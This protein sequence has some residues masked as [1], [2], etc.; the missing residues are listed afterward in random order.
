MPLGKNSYLI[1]C[2]NLPPNEIYIFLWTLWRPSCETGV[3]GKRISGTVFTL[4][5]HTCNWAEADGNAISFAGIQSWTNWN[6]PDD[7]ATWKVLRLPNG[8][9]V[10]WT[11]LHGN[12]SAGWGE[13]M[14]SRLT[15]R[16]IMLTNPVMGSHHA[17]RQPG[18]W[19]G[20][21]NCPLHTSNSL[22]S[23]SACS[24]HSHIPTWPPFWCQLSACEVWYRVRFHHHLP[25]SEGGGGR[26]MKSAVDSLQWST[27]ASYTVVTLSQQEIWNWN[28]NTKVLLC[29]SL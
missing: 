22:I 25:P 10:A 9:A 3:S 16:Q 11:E 13:M 29:G 17:R 27:T 19:I 15:C 20:A 14:K 26:R 4:W 28:I 23:G 7:G 5:V 21:A 24:D 12:P 18:R 8:D 6:W 1:L 2:E